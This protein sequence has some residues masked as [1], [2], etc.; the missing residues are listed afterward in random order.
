M[1]NL[2]LIPFLL[3]LIGCSPAPQSEDGTIDNPADS[4]PAKN[5]LKKSISYHDPDNNWTNFQNHIKVATELRTE[6]VPQLSKREIHMNIPGDYFALDWTSKEIK[7]HGELSSDTCFAEPLESI[8]E[9]QAKSVERSLGCKG[10]SMY[11]DYY[12]YL[13]GIPMKLLEDK[14][15]VTDSVLSRTHDGVAYDVVKI[16]YEPV[17]TSPAWYFY[18]DKNDHS[19]QLC[20]FTSAED[21]SKGG[22]YILY[23]GETIVQ[24]IRMKPKHIWLYNTPERDTLAIEEYQFTMLN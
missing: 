4:S 10:I 22:E 21:E 1:K 19:L 15:I 24:N 13:L 8:S 23:E 16:N 2:Y 9:E 7:I 18:F 14:A 3:V 6:E 17:D 11:K 20:K 12:H 5:L